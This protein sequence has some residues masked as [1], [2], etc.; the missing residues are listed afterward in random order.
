MTTVQLG[1]SATFTCVLP[2]YEFARR[3][4]Q[5]YKQSAGD[6]LNLIVTQ[7]KNTQPV[8]EA[9]FSDSRF[10]VNA[11]N[12][13]MTYLTILRTVQGDEGMYHCA[14]MDWAKLTWSGTYLSLKGNYVICFCAVLE[15][16]LASLC[17]CFVTKIP[18]LISIF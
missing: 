16:L 14:V 6:N 8:Y 17:E 1:E 11:D 4:L 15:S 10:K 7:Q 13:N 5:W 2:D 3:Q 9:G 12:N 18:F